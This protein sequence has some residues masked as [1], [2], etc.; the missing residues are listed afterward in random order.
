MR[1]RRVIEAL[2]IIGE[3]VDLYL[4]SALLAGYD[5]SKVAE[6][7]AKRVA[8]AERGGDM[9][10]LKL[11]KDAVSS[12]LWEGRKNSRL[13]M[14]PWP[15]KNTSAHRRGSNRRKRATTK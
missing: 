4:E 3:P 6:R 13:D 9:V 14:W 5:L 7:T 12:K 11:M 2:I 10:M 1:G 15:T 8:C